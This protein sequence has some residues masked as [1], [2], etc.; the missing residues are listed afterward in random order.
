MPKLKALISLVRWQYQFK[1][2][3]EGYGASRLKQSLARVDFLKRTPIFAYAFLTQRPNLRPN[4]II[5]SMI[6]AIRIKVRAEHLWILATHVEDELALPHF[7]KLV[8]RMISDVGWYIVRDY[9]KKAKVPCVTYLPAWALPRR[10]FLQIPQFQ[11]PK[12]ALARR[13]RNFKQEY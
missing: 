1:T 9:Q 4:L 2:S 5:Y 8:R 3:R 6:R 13:T 10:N 7:K 12:V 11:R